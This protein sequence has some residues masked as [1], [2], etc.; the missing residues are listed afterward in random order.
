MGSKPPLLD[1]KG[2]ALSR[3]HSL[4]G[5]TAV[6]SVIVIST[7]V[8]GNYGLKRGLVNVGVVESWSP[9]PYIQSFVHPWIA[10][11]VVFM[12]AWLTSRLALL[13]WADLSYVL[14]VTSFSYVLSAIVGA[15]YI[16]ERPSR[17]QWLGI[18]II[19]V[20]TLLVVM[21]YPKTTNG[22]PPE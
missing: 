5:K 11:G 1:Q 4:L 2:N 15:M 19:T 22:S 16:N 13:S 10:I 6:V 17:L 9:V 20:G 12:V 14:P 18:S 8:V 3:K 7:N 21:T